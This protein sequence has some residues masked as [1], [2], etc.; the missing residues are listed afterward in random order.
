MNFETTV[1]G[2]RLFNLIYICFSDRFPQQERNQGTKTLS[3]VH[4]VINNEILTTPSGNNSS[5]FS[6]C[7]KLLMMGGTKYLVHFGFSLIRK[8][9]G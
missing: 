7:I 3:G 1:N 5:Y 8:S 4:S 6:A 2:M 9:T